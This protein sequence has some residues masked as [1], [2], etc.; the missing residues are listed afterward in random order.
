MLFFILLVVSLFV[1]S[2]A[3]LIITRSNVKPIEDELSTLLIA[4]DNDDSFNIPIQTS[5]SQTLSSQI[6][7]SELNSSSQILSPELSSSSQTLPSE[8]PPT[9]EYI[10][11]NITQTL[12]SE[13]PPTDEYIQSNITQTL[14][15]EL[16]PTDE[17]IQSSTNIIQTLPPELPPTDEYIQPSTNITQTLSPELPPTDEYIQSNIT[18]TLPPE[19]PLTD[20]Y[21]QPSTNITQT[22]LLPSTDEYIQSSTNITQNILPINDSSDNVLIKKDCIGKWVD[23]INYTENFTNSNLISNKIDIMR[24]KKDIKSK[25]ILKNINKEKLTSH[26]I[27]NID[28]HCTNT[29]ASR[30]VYKK[31]QQKYE[32]TQNAANGGKQ[33]E[34][35]NGEIREKD[36]IDENILCDIDCIG[37]WDDVGNIENFQNN[38]KIKENLT[39]HHICNIDKHCTNTNASRDI[40]KK[41]KQKYKII[42]EVQ[43]DGKLCDFNDGEI[44]EI[45][46]IDENI[47]CDIDCKGDWTNWSECDLSL[48]NSDKRVEQTRTFYITQHQQGNY[49]KDCPYQDGQIETKTCRCDALDCEGYFEDITECNIDD[50]CDPFQIEKE[51]YKYKKQK[52][53][54]TQPARYGGKD[55]QYWDDEI[56]L[57]IC[58]GKNDTKKVLCDIDCVS[59]KNIKSECSLDKCDIDPEQVVIKMGTQILNDSIG[60]GTC[61][62]SNIETINC[63]DQCPPINC[64]FN[65][66]SFG[67][68]DTSDCNNINNYSIQFN[69]NLK[70]TWYHNNILNNDICQTNILNTFSE[71]LNI[72]KT[73]LNIKNINTIDKNTTILIIIN[74]ISK[75][76]SD[77]ISDNLYNINISTEVANELNN[78][79]KCT[80]I[81]PCN[82]HNNIFTCNTLGDIIDD[83]HLIDDKSGKYCNVNDFL[84]NNIEIDGL[85]INQN[86]NVIKKREISKISDAKYGGTCIEPT[87]DLTTSCE[88]ECPVDCFGTWTEYGRC[89]T[90]KC[91]HG[92]AARGIHLTKKLKY[93]VITPSKNGGHKCIDTIYNIDNIKHGQVIEIDC[94]ELCPID[95]QAE[96][97]YSECNVFDECGPIKSDGSFYLENALEKQVK[98]RVIWKELVKPQGKGKQHTHLPQLTDTLISCNPIV[99][100]PINCIYK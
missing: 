94:D 71:Y 32:I 88:N 77:L 66:G 24:F 6:S 98:R 5:S 28:K 86:K 65:I 39:S 35:N 63:A 10:Q 92:E 23:I 25:E 8:L 42:Q 76:K 50:L 19:L 53:K 3:S 47:L 72:S 9:D 73:Q 91:P 64:R 68:C 13:L 99:K 52:F 74:N 1:V 26:N 87:D 81:I 37:I 41:K 20:E 36:C 17:Y 16:P 29:N 96:R 40:Y 38:K 27:C 43:Q 46:C 67:S 48:C 56:I 78:K 7:Q 79:L 12:P 11:S 18:Q 31:K 60:E 89:N 62:I 22:L 59:K 58:D 4:S 33:C 90:S 80:H 85:N 30:N 54:I 34:F 69:L 2:I 83:C 45:D 97:T 75:F 93:N 61:N 44:H 21:I 100:C 55:C 14:L 51:Q 49:G 82:K 84:T 95:A 70:N 15:P 57:K